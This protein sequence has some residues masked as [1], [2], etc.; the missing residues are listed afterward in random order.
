M[1]N[2]LSIV[3]LILLIVACHSP[4]NNQT[5]KQLTAKI[6]SSTNKEYLDWDSVKLNGSIPMIS[7]FKVVVNTFSEPDSITAGDD[8][9]GSFY[10]RRF[11]F[12]NYKAILFEKYH[13][14]LV[15]SGID[16]RKAPNFYLL[17]GKHKFDHTTTVNDFKML[18]PNSTEKNQL[19]GPDMDKLEMISLASSPRTTRNYWAFIFNR[20]N[21]HLQCIDY[22]LAV[23]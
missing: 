14:T 1:K 8:V 20:R 5:K 7:N 17:S 21:S 12:C 19:T 13:D 4:Q 23:K 16:F 9:N 11:Q 3:T 22:D 15:F 6:D 2:R 18:F 10:P